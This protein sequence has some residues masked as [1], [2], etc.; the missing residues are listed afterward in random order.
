MIEPT[1]EW[2]A[3]FRGLC[4][5]EA[6]L[7]IHTYHRH[8]KTLLRCVFKIAFRDDDLA[9]LQ[10]IHEV[11]GGHLFGRYNHSVYL[12]R[13]YNS[14][15][16]YTLQVVN[17]HQLMRV[18]NFLE[19]ALLPAKKAQELATWKK[20]ISLIPD[21]GTRYT[22]E[23]RAQLYDLMSQLKAFHSYQESQVISA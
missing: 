20:A 3:E 19:G 14:R 5:G 21:P 9:L 23:V 13:P 6:Y 1:K 11:I 17:R 22:P 4:W 16:Y 15:P 12:K 10:H 2:I 18:A 7:G 8:E